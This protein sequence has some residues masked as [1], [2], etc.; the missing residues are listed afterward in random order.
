L[1]GLKKED[2]SDNTDE[3]VAGMDRRLDNGRALLHAVEKFWTEKDWADQAREQLEAAEKE[4]AL[5]DTLGKALAPDGIPSQMIA[6]ALGPVN[7]LLAG[8]RLL[9]IDEADILDPLNRAAL[10]NFLLA[11]REDFDTIMVFATSSQAHPSPYPD[12]QVWW[13]ED[14]RIAPVVQKAA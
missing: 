14:G 2:P 10:T 7:D 11:V 12:I 3:Q 9:L 1:A 13:L 4:I 8:E 6:E 5:Y